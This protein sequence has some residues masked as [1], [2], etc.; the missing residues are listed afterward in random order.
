MGFISIANRLNTDRVMTARGGQLSRYHGNGWGRA[1]V[2]DILLNPVYTGDMV[3]NR[4]TFAK[5]FR[6]QEGEATARE[7]V[8]GEGRS[9]T[10]NP[11]GSLS[12]IR[13]PP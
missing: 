1:S 12:P 6:I 5:F 2:R 13:T 7:Y 11:I 4:L 8:P 3:W 9:K 10:P